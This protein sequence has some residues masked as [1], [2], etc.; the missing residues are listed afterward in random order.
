MFGDANNWVQQGYS[1]SF[2]FH[3]DSMF[4]WEA[5]HYKMCSIRKAVAALT[6]HLALQRQNS[7]STDTIP[8]EPSAL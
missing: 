5:V 2:M 4:A 6:E 1:P 8:L 3:A 7:D